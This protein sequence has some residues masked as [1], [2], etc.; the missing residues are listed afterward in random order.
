MAKKL[1]VVAK[2]AAKINAAGYPIAM[3]LRF[4]TAC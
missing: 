3:I 1:L 2:D 4:V